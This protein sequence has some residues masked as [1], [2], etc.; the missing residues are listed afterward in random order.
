[1]SAEGYQPSVW[2]DPENSAEA[3]KKCPHCG[4]ELAHP[5][6]LRDND[7]IK[8]VGLFS[9]YRRHRQAH[10]PWGDDPTEDGEGWQQ[11]PYLASAYS[12]DMSA[13]WEPE[14]GP[15]GDPDEVVGH[16]YDVTISY[17]TQLRATVVAPTESRAKDKAKDLE[18]FG[19]EDSTGSVPE[20]HVTHEIHGEARTRQDVTRSDERA[21]RMEG[22][23]W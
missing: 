14:D 15:S 1:M 19:E 8:A 11:D 7:A 4:E 10:F 12:G 9:A 20:K 6:D 23:P 5:D 18:M 3:P 22:W 13:L 2:D 17:E 21:E 16:V